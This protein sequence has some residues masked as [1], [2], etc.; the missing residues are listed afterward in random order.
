[1]SGVGEDKFFGVLFKQET[2][3]VLRVGLHEWYVKNGRHYIPWKLNIDG[4]NPQHGQELDPYRIWIAEIMLQQTQL[5]V[6]LPYWEKWMHVFPTLQSL[7]QA[8]EQEVLL[9]WQGLGYYSRARR[10][11]Q[12]AKQLLDLIGE[13]DPCE[14]SSWPHELETW[15][16]LPGIGKTTAGSII[17]S[18]FD[19]R[20]VLLDGNVKRVLGRLVANSSPE[21]ESISALWKLSE[22]LLDL[23]KPRQ[24][25]QAL[26]DLGAVVCKPRNPNC[27]DCP[28][29]TFCIAYS[30]QSPTDF[31]V[32]G[33]NTLPPRQVIGVGIVFNSS[34][35][36][37]ID[38]RLND[39]LLGGLWEFPG[40]KQEPNESIEETIVRELKEEL[41]IEVQVG[42]LLISLEHSYSHKR[43]CFVVHLCR[44]LAGEPQPLQSQQFRWVKPNT[45]AKYPFPAANS[46]II[47]ALHNH[48]DKHNSIDNS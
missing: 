20:G 13:D 37:L 7:N 35:E 2:V 33:S 42:E 39:G 45:L 1:M 14:P 43:L 23:K 48:L 8:S 24:F 27:F 6:M 41:A 29:N 32:K 30:S 17:S 22:L 36:V 10:I 18:A 12:A 47:A 28:W 4:T 19:I 5:K 11:Y 40:G 16:S 31:P 26:M 46:K 38:Q 15:M 21:K 44:W 9:L 34:Q 25:N 3:K